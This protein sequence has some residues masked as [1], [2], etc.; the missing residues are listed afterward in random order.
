M[1]DILQANQGGMGSS[2]VL[3]E[4]SGNHSHNLNVASPRSVEEVV[5]HIETGMDQNQPASTPDP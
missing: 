2:K 1:V 4:A 5:V 3:E